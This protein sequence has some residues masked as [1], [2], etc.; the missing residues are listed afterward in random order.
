[1]TKKKTSK[2]KASKILLPDLLGV[3]LAKITNLK[4]GFD[5]FGDR[6]MHAIEKEQLKEDT[7]TL[8]SLMQIFTYQ[9]KKVFEFE[10]L[11]P[12]TKDKTPWRKQKQRHLKK[13]ASLIC[14]WTCQNENHKIDGELRYIKT[15]LANEITS[16]LNPVMM[17]HTDKFTAQLM[18]L[19]SG[20]VDETKN[21]N[22][23][24]AILVKSFVAHWVIENRFIICDQGLIAQEMR[25]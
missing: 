12:K 21:S 15:L 3:D 17:K 11:D 19:S 5:F 1:M 6:P 23:Y 7:K 25:F 9:G 8:C 2:K 18:L 24:W 22:A 16:V 14:R 13:S 4:R 10:N 20:I